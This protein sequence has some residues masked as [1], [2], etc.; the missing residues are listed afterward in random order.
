MVFSW[1]ATVEGG[2]AVWGF[3]KM[4]GR[5]NMRN[6]LFC[7]FVEVV[8][9]VEPDLLLPLFDLLFA[10]VFILLFKVERFNWGLFLRDLKLRLGR[11]KGLF[12]W[13]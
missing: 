6:S 7:E 2:G 9:V 11:L 3:D 8:V 5:C 13:N 12:C 1:S 4:V 10:R